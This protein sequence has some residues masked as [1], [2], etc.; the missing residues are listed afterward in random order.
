M[1]FGNHSIEEWTGLGGEYCAQTKTDISYISHGFERRFHSSVRG[2]R[3][4][5]TARGHMGLVNVDVTRGDI[6]CLISGGRM[7]VV[8]RPSTANVGHFFLGEAYIHGIMFG[9][10]MGTLQKSLESPRQFLLY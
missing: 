8:F 7:P 2:R 4:V 3:L 5:T 10:G 9:E 6:V 1:K